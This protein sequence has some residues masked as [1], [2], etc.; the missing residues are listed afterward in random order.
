[1]VVQVEGLLV[2]LGID[3]GASLEGLFHLLLS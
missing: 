3:L 2:S 1:M